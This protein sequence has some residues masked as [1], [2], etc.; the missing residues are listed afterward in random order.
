MLV[1]LCDFSDSTMSTSA[2]N[3]LERTRV[4]SPQLSAKAASLQS[5]LDRFSMEGSF[6]WCVAGIALLHPP[7]LTDTAQRKCTR[8][9]RGLGSRLGKV[10][11]CLAVYLLVQLFGPEIVIE[12]QRR[13]A[14]FEAE[15]NEKIEMAKEPLKR[16]LQRVLKVHCVS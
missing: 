14:W 1:L 2:I 10:N 15:A 16:E 8:T 12:L 5:T 11:P 9:R 3:T 13:L 4:T 6:G 7:P